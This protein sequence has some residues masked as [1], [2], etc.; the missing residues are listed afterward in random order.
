MYTLIREGPT[1]IRVLE[2]TQFTSDASMP[3]KQMMANS[4]SMATKK[5]RQCDFYTVHDST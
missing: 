4:A 1:G 2:K 5:N 3:Y